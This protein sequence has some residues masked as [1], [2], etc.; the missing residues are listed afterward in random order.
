MNRKLLKATR[1]ID[2]ISPT[3]RQEVVVAVE[4]GHIT[5]VNDEVRS[6]ESAATELLDY[7]GLCL[8]PGLIDCHTHT[9]MDAG[10]WVP[11][12]IAD[13]SDARLYKRSVNN[14]QAALGSG[15][16]TV[17]DNAARQLPILGLREKLR[18]G[19]TKGPRLIVSGAAIT[20][21]EGH[22]WFIGVTAESNE[23][24]S[25]LI[26]QHIKEG[27]DFL[28]VMA[29]G[30]NLT[31]TSNP[32]RAQFELEQLKIIVR[33]ARTA[34]LKVSAH[35]HGT[36]GISQCVEAGVDSIDHCS[37]LGKEDGFQFDPKIVALMAERGI[38]V[39][40][41]LSAIFE[42]FAENPEVLE[43]RLSNLRSMADMGV[44]IVAG[45]DA[46]VDGVPF[47]RPWREIELLSRSG[48]SN[49]DAIRA[50]TSAAAQ[51]LGIDDQVGTVVSGKE[52]DLIAVDGNPL[53]DLS[54]LRRIKMVMKS[55]EVIFSEINS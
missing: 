4:S 11:E 25:T 38:Y 52:A 31:R 24:L 33:E 10:K 41:T 30:G 3:A 32:R 27:V 37:W 2:G 49:L 53:E 21:K 13:R 35:A 54:A 43:R 51:C 29:T 39:V 44:S 14:I 5:T 16:T 18:S 45:T 8:M 42:R 26:H 19:Q 55:G 47:G 12:E 1:L 48:L 28:K 6:M 9:Q 34:G 40:P 20:R 36:E 50:A 22:C 23:Q 17:R 46:G 15:V 7:T